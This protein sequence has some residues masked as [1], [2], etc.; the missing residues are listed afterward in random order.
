[1]VFRLE[2]RF[3]SS[4]GSSPDMKLLSRTSRVLSFCR[5]PNSVG[6]VPV[7]PGISRMLKVSRLDQV[8]ISRGRVPQKPGMFHKRKKRIAGRVIPGSFPFKPVL[9]RSRNSRLFVFA[10]AFAFAFAFVSSPSFCSCQKS[11]SSKRPSNCGLTCNSRCV[12]RRRLLR[13]DGRF[14]YKKLPSRASCWRVDHPPPASEDLPIHSGIL[15]CNWFLERITVSRLVM[16]AHSSGIVP[17][18]R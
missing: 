2:E 11:V 18:N 17:C 1:M 6:R 3:P 15:V 9:D 14:P 12:N 10:F 5:A 7:R 8:P 16:E 4:V 13:E